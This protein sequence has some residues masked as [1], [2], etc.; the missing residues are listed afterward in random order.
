MGRVGDGEAAA[1]QPLGRW[2]PQA[3]PCQVEQPNRHS[4]VDGGDARELGR[5][6]VEPI[7]PRAREYRELEHRLRKR[8]EKRLDELM[9]IFA[10]TAALPQGRAVIDQNPHPWTLPHTRC[11]A[12]D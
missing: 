7:F 8:R 12:W 4:A 1:R 10:G 9:G 11:G 5:L 6:D 2:P 3:M